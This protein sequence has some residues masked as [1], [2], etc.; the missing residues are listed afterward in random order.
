MCLLARA[1][2]CGARGYSFNIYCS[3]D[4]LRSLSG[5]FFNAAWMCPITDGK[6]NSPVVTMH[7]QDTTVRLPVPQSLKEAVPDEHIR[8]LVYSL[9]P[10]TEVLNESGVALFRQALPLERKVKVGPC[11]PSP[12]ALLGPE[13]CVAAAARANPQ[14]SPT[15]IKPSKKGLDVAH[16]L[17]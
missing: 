10:D 1:I 4:K 15:V 13:A 7:V 3:G 14:M 6:K 9:A 17:R 11:L 16:L 2:V 12:N 8:F 5:S